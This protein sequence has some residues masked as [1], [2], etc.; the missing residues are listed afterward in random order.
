MLFAGGANSFPK[1]LKLLVDQD[2]RVYDAE[3]KNFAA[4]MFLRTGCRAY[5]NLNFPKLSTISKLMYKR[6]GFIQ[7]GSVRTND[8]AV[9][10]Q[11]RK[12]GLARMA[13]A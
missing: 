4:L 8:L 1:L 2:K 13:P 9:F 6:V 5:S 11:E 12:F 10:L 7:E 3:L